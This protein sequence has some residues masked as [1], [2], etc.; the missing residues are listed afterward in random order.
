MEKFVNNESELNTLEKVVSSKQ[1]VSNAEDA[2][3]EYM[4][5]ERGKRIARFEQLMSRDDF[6][7]FREALMLFDDEQ[8]EMGELFE[9]RLKQYFDVLISFLEMAVSRQSRKSGDG[10]LYSQVVEELYFINCVKVRKDNSYR[11][12][13]NHP[14]LLINE[15][16]NND[17][18]TMIDKWEN[19]THSQAKSV[20]LEGTDYE[21]LSSVFDAK[22]KNRRRMRIYG[23]N[24]V[25]EIK[26]EKSVEENGFVDARPFVQSEECTEIPIIRLW[27]KIKNYQELHTEKLEFINI[28]LFGKLK[29]YSEND[30]K[31]VEKLSGIKIN[32]TYFNHEPMTGEYFFTDDTGEEIYDLMDMN[33]LQMLAER[34]EIVIFLDMN[35]FYRQGQAVK[36]VEEKSVDTTCR[37]N[38]DRS[39][40]R[41]QF[42]DKAAIYRTIYN[43]IGQ[44]INMS[45]SNMSATFEF[46]EKLYRNLDM[47]LKEK[48]DIYLYI[49]YGASIGGFNLSNNGICNDEYYDGVSLT[50]CRLSKLDKEQFNE[51]YGMFL[52]NEGNDEKN[53]DNMRTKAYVPIRFWK[54]F[55]S[56]SNEYCD[57]TLNRFGQGDINKITDIVHFFNESHLVLYYTIHAGEKKV[58]IQYK[59]EMSKKPESMKESDFCN[60][61]KTMSNIVKVILKYAFGEEE[62]YC[63]NRYFERLLIYSVISNSDDIGD[64]IFAYWIASQ[65]YTVK[66][67]IRE[68]QKDSEEI[69][70]EAVNSNNNFANS[71]NRF[72]VRKTIYSIVKRLADMRMRNVP[73]MEDFFSASFHGEVCPEVTDDNL[74]KTYRQISDYCELLD[75]TGGY[76]YSNSM[77]LMNK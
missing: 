39:L 77:T 38:F 57:M 33:D 7:R 5:E 29:V 36:S 12:Y 17:T 64:L 55:K 71:R 10:L 35:C 4:K 20:T 53:E 28:A 67:Q 34:Y 16:L 3:F 48:T 56:I 44:W 62:L 25:Y 22:K 24:M 50:V 43:R 68:K 75:Y 30:K 63:M 8:D 51:D 23:R 37:W 32:C 54:L 45:E 42:K 19:E 1:P 40:R 47:L 76:L 2:F 14:I 52:N 72:K 21:I 31:I 49:R 61:Q 41:D 18:K 46:D 70:Q 60:L 13:N 11:I 74:D 59:L 6:I 26:R 58:S 69:V 73:N 66:E 15:R 65:W 9:E 27:E